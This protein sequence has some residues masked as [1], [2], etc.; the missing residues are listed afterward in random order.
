MSRRS[1][2]K[3]ETEHYVVQLIDHR[4]AEQSGPQLRELADAYHGLL[5]VVHQQQAAILKLQQQL[6]AEQQAARLR[7]EQRLQQEEE[8]RRQAEERR[9]QEEERRR[10]EEERRRQEE[11][12][13]RLEEERRRRLSVVV[14]VALDEDDDSNR[15]T[16]APILRDL[17]ARGGPSYVSFDFA[18][19]S[20]PTSAAPLVLYFVSLATTRLE[21]N[22]SQARFNETR[23]QYR[24][25]QLPPASQRRL[26][27]LTSDISAM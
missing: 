10:Q 22:Y 11:E 18:S 2:L 4:I 14:A 6:S 27:V 5:E 8:R 13:R 17:N 9:R 16:Y 15:Q 24:T 25:R 23:A 19:P 7:E 20:G 26:P 21:E 1:P 3:P 12:R